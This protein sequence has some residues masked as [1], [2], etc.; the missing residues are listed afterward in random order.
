[1]SFAVNENHEESWKL[2]Q[3]A[4]SQ[5]A[6]T[7]FGHF[8]KAA[9]IYNWIHPQKSTNTFGETGYFCLFHPFLCKLGKKD[10][11]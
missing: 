1:M 8:E 11:V 4:L 10:T 3:T 5:G 7:K 2:S 6:N 9:R